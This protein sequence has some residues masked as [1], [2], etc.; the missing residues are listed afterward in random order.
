MI[1]QLS[2][3]ARA[4]HRASADGMDYGETMPYSSETV[5][6][7]LPPYLPAHLPT[8]PP[9]YSQLT[10]FSTT[11]GYEVEGDKQYRCAPGLKKA[12]EDI[13]QH[14]PEHE[15]KCEPRGGFPHSIQVDFRLAGGKH[16]NEHYKDCV[17]KA[18]LAAKK[19][20]GVEAGADEHLTCRAFDMLVNEKD[21]MSNPI[22]PLHGYPN[23]RHHCKEKWCRD[24]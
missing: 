19:A 21:D 4:I 23:A 20:A 18:I 24:G 2:R 13:C 11:G 6:I 5:S 3:R 9:A 16:K 7:N 22:P 17:P 8:C 14:K 1:E 12:L 15:F 10:F